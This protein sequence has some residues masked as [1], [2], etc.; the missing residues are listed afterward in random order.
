MKRT[1]QIRAGVTCSLAAMAVLGLTG[2]DLAAA[3]QDQSGARAILGSCPDDAK[4][5]ALV[6]I[7][8]TGSS[9]SANLGT[10]EM[11]VVRDKAMRVALCGGNLRVTAFTSSTAATGIVFDDSIP[12]VGAT[13]NARLRRVEEAV[14]TVLSDVEASF[15]ETVATLHG[16]SGGTDVAGQFGLG[17]EYSA[18]LGDG[19][20]LDLV[21]VTDGFHNTGLNVASASSTEEAA[22]LAD[23]LP[24]VDLSGA[25]VTVTGIGKVADRL[26]PTEVVDRLKA[27]Y[28]SACENT[29]AATC[30][31]VTDYTGGR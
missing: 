18:Q 16:G 29:G 30:T 17:R 23:Q 25:D 22:A 21:L 7:D 11:A 19:Y 3:H 10:A 24:A 9:Q 1:R 4:V 13:D 2:C 20:V 15:P 26:P 31:V 5:G 28:Q 8:A 12:L 14:A 27:F 6:S